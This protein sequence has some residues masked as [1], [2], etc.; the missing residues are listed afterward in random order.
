MRRLAALGIVLSAG[1]GLVAV[2]RSIADG[3]N[4]P[5]RAATTRSPASDV[6]V[7]A[8]NATAP[9][10]TDVVETT[11]RV[12]TAGDP[13]RVL[14]VGDSE[15]G[16]LSRFLEAALKPAGLTKL[17][18]DYT[19]SSGFV[20]SDFFDWPAHLAQ[21]VPTAAADIVVALFGANDGQPFKNMPGTPV[22]SAEW[23]AE[24]GKRIGA[25]MDYLRADGRTLIW[26]GVP[27]GNSP[28]LAKTLPVQ[29]SVVAEQ[30]AARPDVIFVDTWRHF[31]GI[32]GDYAPLV[33]DPRD[34]NYIAV[35]S[36]TDG[37]HLNTVG[38]K[39]LASYVT[40]VIDQQLLA[41]GAVIPADALPP[42]TVDPEGIGSYTV[43]AG[44]ALS[45]IAD[46]TGTTVAAI[47]AQNGWA[48]E[49]HLIYPGM[50][51]DLPAKSA[52]S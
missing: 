24:Y 7:P 44:D 14:L 52:G 19:V 32:G 41:R 46:S 28:S 33:L 37:F 12:P 42:T 10:V 29:N 9:T 8:S 50:K 51:I 27:N 40:G 6:S 30:I 21:V 1:V 22:D 31:S 20:R 34:G 36:G 35:R 38:E 2:I 43:V 45:T 49:R 13:A 39:I 15:A 4:P 26:V 18:T 5:S 11:P 16:G 47:V 17:T 3:S 23:R 25:A 48:D